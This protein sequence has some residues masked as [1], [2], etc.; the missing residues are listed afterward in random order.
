M[1]S[2]SWWV[3]VKNG[4]GINVHL[5]LALWAKS[6]NLG[7]SLKA[8][9]CE[10][11]AQGSSSG[12]K[13]VRNSNEM[14]LTSKGKTPFPMMSVCASLLPGIARKPASELVLCI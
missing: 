8:G 12:E 9:L 3:N 6:C 5:P 10:C 2:L 7:T 4:N 14:G 13:K 1:E 11:S